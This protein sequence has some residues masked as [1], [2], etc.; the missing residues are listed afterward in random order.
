MRKSHRAEHPLAH[1][2][3]QRKGSVLLTVLVIIGLLTFAIYTFAELSV[4]EVE[5]TS[6]Y[7]R[8]TQTRALAD[9]GLELASALLADP[10]ERASENYY[11][12]PEL[13]AG[14]LMQDAQGARGRGR[15]SVIAPNES[16]ITSTA[17]RYGF[18]DESGKLN[19][20]EAVKWD[21]GAADKRKLLMFL[22]LMTEECADA[23]LDWVD[24]D[25]LAREFGAEADFYEGL[26]EPYAPTNGPLSS[27]DE[28]LLVRGVSREL[29]FGEDA[30]RNGLLDLGEDLNGDG[31]LDR[32]WAAYLTVYSKEANV[33]ADG[34]PRIKLNQDDLAALFDELA[35]EFDDETATFVVA[36][37]MNGVSTEN[38][39]PQQGGSSGGNSGGGRRGRRGGGGGQSSGNNSNGN[40]PSNPSGSS[41][42]E[43]AAGSQ[44]QGDQG[45]Q[46]NP[47]SG[48]PQSSGSRSGG[49]SSR[50]GSGQSGSS[51][52]GNNTIKKGGLEIPRSGGGGNTINSIYDLVDVKV[53]AKVN[54]TDQTLE[55]PWKTQGRDLGQALPLL[56]DALTT[57]EESTIKGRVNINQ[58]SREVLLG[59]PGMT[60]QLATSIAMQKSVGPNGEPVTD[61]MDSHGTSGWLLVEGLADVATMK[62]IDKYITA[63]GDVYRVQSVGYFDAGGPAT[64][65]EAVFDATA[66]PPKV[67][68]FRDLTEL[69]AGYSRTQLTT[70]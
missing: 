13:F 56:V 5:A 23:I 68:F 63:R 62:Q 45:Q 22:P 24:N 29:L 69:G 64:R 48:T 67:L 15:Y 30:N 1:A 12:R 7:A 61:F 46:S 50:G 33:R 38:S 60:E 26:A 17:V 18:S 32:G 65:L 27:L 8:S 42:D 58:A 4:S 57:I 20:N 35:A 14:I 59:L 37:R 9:S 2:S 41:S 70:Q 31:I 49:G 55:S 54:G 43:S 51:G 25:A 36:Y 39:N 16:D 40:S 28:L 11:H 53:K 34:S 3:T 52:G 6:M 21:I 10:L 44:G 66:L 19:L 47:G